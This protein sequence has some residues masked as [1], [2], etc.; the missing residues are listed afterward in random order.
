MFV[1]A[2]DVQRRSGDRGDRASSRRGLRV[3]S[4]PG[5]GLSALRPRLAQARYRKRAAG[6]AGGAG[7]RDGSMRPAV[8]VTTVN[9]LLQ[10]VPPRECDRAARA[11]SRK[12]RRGGRSRCAGRVPRRAMAM[13]APARCASRAISRCAAASSICGRRAASSRCGSISSA[14]TLDAI[15]RFDAE[16]QLV[17]R[18]DRR[19][20]SCCPP[21]KRRS[22]A[23]AISRFRAGYVAAFGPAERDDPLYETRQR[24]PQAAGHGALAAAVLSTGSTRCSIIV[25]RALVLLGHQAE[26]AKNARLELIADYYE[27]REQFRARRTT[28]RRTHQGAALQAAEAGSALSHRRGMEG[29]AGAARGARSL[30]VPGAGIDEVASMRAAAW[31]AISRP[32]ARRASSMSSRPRPI[33]SRRCRR[34]ASASI[35]ACWTRRLGRAHGRRAVRSRPSRHPHASRTGPMR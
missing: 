34:P 20:S 6:D 21:A 17:A 13:S 33:I 4:F 18:P 15:R 25:P 30:A 23:D 26:E 5:L 12:R 14:T 1:A 10:R 31:A 11:S 8:I 19:R 9:A 27:T 29:G 28:P 7:A 24:R 32:S 22:D 35:V 3:L 16:T 2:D